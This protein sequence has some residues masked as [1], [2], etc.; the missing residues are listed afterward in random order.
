VSRLRQPG[1]QSK[2]QWAGEPLLL[3]DWQAFVV[4]SI[5]GW[6]EIA[7]GLRRF[8]KAY[9]EV[10]RK[11]GKTT[12]ASGVGLYLLDFDGEAGA[13]IYCTATKRDQ[14]RLCWSEAMRMVQY[15]PAL[16]KRIK[17]VESRANLHVLQ[18]NSKFEA[19]GA[20]NDSMDGLNPH[21]YI[22]DELHAHKTRGIVDALET[23]AGARRQPL[24]FYITTAGVAK[25]SVYSETHDYARRVVEG[26][27]DDDQW[28]SFIAA[29]DE[30]DDWTDPAVY[31]K[32]NPSLGV[33]VQLEE[34][35][36]ERDRAMDSPGRQNSFRR[37]REMAGI[38]HESGSCLF[39]HS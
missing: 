31:I 1:H 17:V 13:E 11:N 22:I 36:A 24:A 39:A 4:G 14:A 3:Q 34:L 23:A 30:D 2:G 8:R 32:A 19:L 27:I 37:L 9:T 21:A 25:E 15:T 6:K 33:T 16:K 7:T 29:L 5:F 20:D 18:T 10:A 28:F 38:T 26:I 35:M 12:L